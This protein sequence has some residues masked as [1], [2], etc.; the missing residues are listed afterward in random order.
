MVLKGS[1]AGPI[2]RLNARVTPI[3][4]AN[5]ADTEIG[6]LIVGTSDHQGTAANSLVLSNI[7][8]DGDI[9]MLVNDNGDSKE[10]LLANGDTADLQLGHGMATATIKTA[11]GDL[12]LSPGG[13]VISTKD[14]RSHA[15]RPAFQLSETD[16]SADQNW[17]IRSY[18]GGLFVSTQNDA[19]DSG[20]DKLTITQAGVIGITGVEGS[21]ASGVAKAWAR[22]NGAGTMTAG[23]FNMTGI[24]KNSTGNYTWT[25]DTNFANTNWCSASTDQSQGNVHHVDG[26]SKAVG[27]WVELAFDGNTDST[28]QDGGLDAAFFG[29][30]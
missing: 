17:E 28:A 1:S 21:L 23:S 19:F 18:N 29:D 25:F 2:I 12:T 3:A 7:D 27:T 26:G 15:T 11:S 8:D 30:Q 22:H 6:G 14:I 10:F 4:A 13:N 24:A 9:Q 5:S 16:G 20:S